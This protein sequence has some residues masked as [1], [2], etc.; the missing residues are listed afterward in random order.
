[1]SGANQLTDSSL[2]LAAICAAH[3]HKFRS[4]SAVP[5]RFTTSGIPSPRSSLFNWLEL[6]AAKEANWPEEQQGWIRRR[7]CSLVVPSLA[8]IFTRGESSCF[9]AGQGDMQPRSVAALRVG[10][11]GRPTA[12][13]FCPCARSPLMPSQTEPAP[14]YV[15]I[16]ISLASL[17]GRP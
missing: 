15:N 7:T 11:R 3:A 1:M 2:T 13:R 12:L 16:T 5:A 8:Q 17:A 14:P 6:R 10:R 9:Y 4:N